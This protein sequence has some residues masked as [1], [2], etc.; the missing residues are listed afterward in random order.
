MKATRTETTYR[1]AQL[2]GQ[3]RHVRVDERGQRR[4]QGLRHG[5]GPLQIAARHLGHPLPGE[6]DRAPVQPLHRDQVD[7]QSGHHPQPVPAAAQPPEELRLALRRDPAQNPVGGHH[8]QRPDPVGGV[9]E[10]P[11]QDAQSA[12]QGVRDRAHR[13]R[14][15]VERGQPVRDRRRGHR[16][17]GRARADPGG[18]A[19]RVDGDGVQGAGGDEDSALDRPGQPVPGGVG[20]DREPARGGVRHGL[21]YVVGGG[22]LDQPAGPD[23][24]AGLEGGG[25]G[26]G[27]SVRHGEALLRS[28]FGGARK[29]LPGKPDNLCQVMIERVLLS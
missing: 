4:R 14:R 27:G 16:A 18:A 3:L 15:A 7:L 25:C 6:R 28:R 17:P 22:G 8:L 26:S 2:L 23:R 13:G 10:L 24:E 9:P 21:P 5:P 20:G 11:G 12:A 29:S 19:D 1:A